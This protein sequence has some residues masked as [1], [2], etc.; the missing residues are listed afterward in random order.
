[1][2]WLSI[3]FVFEYGGWKN[4]SIIKYH[5]VQKKSTENI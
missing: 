2:I 1:M 5:L 3:C 4:Y